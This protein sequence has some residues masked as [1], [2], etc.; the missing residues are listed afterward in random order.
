MKGEVCCVELRFSLPCADARAYSIESHRR[1]IMRF[2]SKMFVNKLS[3]GVI[4]V[5]VD[6]SACF[7]SVGF[8]KAVAALCKIYWP[9]RG[10]RFG[11]SG[12][13]F[14]TA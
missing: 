2:S 1:A 13:E 10:V 8:L 12:R 3:S 5:S 14:P 7:A 4:Y 11:T 6:V 9:L